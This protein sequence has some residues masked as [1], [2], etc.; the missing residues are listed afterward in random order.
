MISNVFNFVFQGRILA[1][2]PPANPKSDRLQKGLRTV[3]VGTFPAM[4]LLT[5]A[6]PFDTLV[7][8][9]SVKRPES[10]GGLISTLSSRSE[11][12]NADL[13]TRALPIATALYAGFPISVV[14]I[15]S[16]RICYF[17]IFDWL[18]Q[19]FKRYNTNTGAWKISFGFGASLVAGL[20]TYPFDSIRR[21]QMIAALQGGDCS[22]WTA[23]ERLMARGGVL[24]LFDGAW[25]NVLRAVL[26]IS[27]L[28]AYDSLLTRSTSWLKRRTGKK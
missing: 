24:G 20:V 12:P 14:G 22:A 2:F 13:L 19:L 25:V 26:S 18:N 8:L 10:L 5:F 27:S 9:Y 21:Y 3:I 16:Y 6:Y 15:N 11:L 1:L 23:A 17:L 7:D 28:I 4:T